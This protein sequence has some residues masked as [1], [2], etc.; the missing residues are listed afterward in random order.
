MGNIL[1]FKSKTQRVEQAAKYYY[2]ATVRFGW[3][4][5]SNWLLKNCPEQL[6]PQVQRIVAERIKRENISVSN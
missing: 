4:S 1:E 3:L 6:I 5:A 2:K